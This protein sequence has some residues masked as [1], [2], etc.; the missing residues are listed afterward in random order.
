MPFLR[1]VR[2]KRG[3][4]TTYLIHA[5]RE[6]SGR[7]SQ[8]LYAFRSPGGVRVGRLALDPEVRREIEAQHP[9]IAFD[10]NGILAGQQV[11]DATP[12][13]RRP[14]R[15]PA[16]PAGEH[17]PAPAP[18]RRQE[19]PGAPRLTVPAA[20]EGETPEQ[21]MR[22][23]AHWHGILCEQLPARV[24]DPVRREALMALVNRLNPAGWLEPD[25]I[26]VGLQDAGEALERLSHV[27]ARRRRKGRRGARTGGDGVGEARERSGETPTPAGPEAA[28]EPPDL[29]DTAEVDDPDPHE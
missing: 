19:P 18:P 14:R 22:F 9:A 10:W 8:L 6:G 23:L 5:P 25:E 24:P 16:S 4:E 17:S 7:E 27:F 13:E 29:P 26:T 1:V 2:D 12:T 11:I 15:R 21:R 20:V 3:Y 28:A